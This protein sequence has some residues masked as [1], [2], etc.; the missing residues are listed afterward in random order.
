MNRRGNQ[1]RI[2]NVMLRIELLGPFDDPQL[3]SPMYV[4]YR[5]LS[6]YSLKRLSVVKKFSAVAYLL[7]GQTFG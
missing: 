1:V 6:M 5:I 3:L 4:I 7:N 2:L